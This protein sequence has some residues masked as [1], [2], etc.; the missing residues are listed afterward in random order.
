MD[1]KEAKS[2]FLM[3]PSQAF[4]LQLAAVPLFLLV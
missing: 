1:I 4:Q 2:S 3:R